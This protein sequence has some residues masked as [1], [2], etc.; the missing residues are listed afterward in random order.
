MKRISFWHFLVLALLLLLTR[1][2]QGR[3]RA[4]RN[5]N[6]QYI[7]TFIYDKKSSEV[8]S[9]EKGKNEYFCD[10][11]PGFLTY[12]CSNPDMQEIVAPNS[13]QKVL[14]S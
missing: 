11:F 13:Q 3:T 14:L 6:S 5:Q 4:A 10:N 2:R 12:T 9:P 1:S 7:I 8:Y